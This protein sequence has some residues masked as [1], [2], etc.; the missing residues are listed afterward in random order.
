MNG[1]GYS[2][3]IVGVPEYDTP[4]NDAGI[5]YVYYGNSSMGLSVC[6]RQFMTDMS[7]PLSLLGEVDSETDV[8]IRL[9]GRMPLGRE[10]VKLQWQAAPLGCAFSNA[11]VVSGI[12]AEWIDTGTGGT[13]I[14]ERI[15]G[16]T[17]DIAYH[18]CARMVYRSGNRLG[19]HAGRW[20]GFGPK[21]GWKRISEPRPT[22]QARQ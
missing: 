6:P 2:D 4:I 10:Q 15:T 9:T 16:L 18:W 20:I 13:N 21:D 14:L 8:I 1:D 5:A 19:Q 11:A 22:P 17:R 3:V 7:T 12:S